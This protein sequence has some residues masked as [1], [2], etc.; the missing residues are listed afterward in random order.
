MNEEDEVS[1][2]VR[3]GLNF[4]A[5]NTSPT[6]T[7]YLYD[8]IIYKSTIYEAIENNFEGYSK[9]NFYPNNAGYMSGIKEGNIGVWEGKFRVDDEGYKY[10]LYKGGRGPSVLYAKINDETEYKKIGEILIN[11]GGYMFY[12]TSL[13]YYQVDLNKN[14]IVYFKV[15]LLGRTLSTG[16]TAWINIGISKTDN[17]NQVRTLNKNDIVGIAY[18]FDEPY[19]FESGDPYK[20]E[21]VFDSYSFFD[22]T[23]VSVDSPNFIP[24]DNSGVTDL[25]KMIDHDTT[26]YMHTERNFRISSQNP[27]ILNFDLGKYYSF[28]CIIFNRGPTKGWYL[29]LNLIVLTS[30]DGE[31]WVEKGEYVTQ[32]S[33]DKL[34]ILNFETKLYERYIQLKI[35]KQMYGVYI[36]IAT[37]DFIEKD[38]KLYQLSPEEAQMEGKDLIEINFDNFPYFGHSYLLKQNCGI[39]FLIEET[40]GIKIKVCNKFD[41]KVTVKVDNGQTKE[42]IIQI[43]AAENK[44]YPVE[45]RD[46]VK[47][48]HRFKIEV[49]EGTFDFEFILYEK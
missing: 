33:G 43:Y 31:T 30:T 25:T 5:D 23:L 4:Q 35:S 26:T 21:K 40:T 17:A 45:I 36:A 11:Q 3:L 39:S 47:G 16:S 7:D 18:K 22:Y 46:L 20:T 13:A 48:K 44:D 15:Y 12:G 29:P 32:K 42:E 19:V 24:W 1:S 9:I 6:Q 10:I 37:I 49:N 34:A 38:L 2:T 41:S 28:D 8:S 14:D 27:L